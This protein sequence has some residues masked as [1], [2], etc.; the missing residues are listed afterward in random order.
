MQEFHWLSYSKVQEGSFFKYCFL[1]DKE[2]E[3][4]KG[5][6]IKLGAFVL[7]PF[8]K[9]KDA[10]EEFLRHENSN[11]HKDCSISL[12]MFYMCMREKQMTSALK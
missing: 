9:W 5:Q 11:Y 4:G 1:F 12:K 7:S 10:K 6:H 2:K 3:V 8:T